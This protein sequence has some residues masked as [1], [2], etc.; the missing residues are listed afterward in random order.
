MTI[1][2]TPVFAPEE[3]LAGKPEPRT[4][5]YSLG[6]TMHCLITGTVPQRPFEFPSLKEFNVNVPQELEDIIMCSLS[7]RP[8]DRYVNAK[9]MKEALEKLSNSSS[10]QF[11]PTIIPS[12]PGTIISTTPQTLI[13][14]TPRT[15]RSSPPVE[16]TGITSSPV[17][18]HTIPSVRSDVITKG[19]NMKVILIIAVIILTASI[20]FYYNFTSDLP[21]K[22][23]SLYKQG[24]YEEAVKYYDKI[25]AGDEKNIDALNRKGE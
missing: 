5:L 4:D 9:Q 15:M 16:K 21:G 20:I 17:I 8:S 19:S 14:D 25:L 12:I 6:A 18:P 23:L 7:R 13:S 24:K 2:G 1:V 3:L 11:P 10:R 22:A